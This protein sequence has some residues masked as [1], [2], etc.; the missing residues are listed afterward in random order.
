MT[1]NKKF[2][3]S[4]IFSRDKNKLAYRLLFF[5]IISSTSL[6]VIATAF[7]LYTSF[8]RGKSNVVKSLDV[9]DDSFRQSLENALWEFNFSQVESILTGIQAK[10][11]VSQ[12]ELSAISGHQWKLGEGDVLDDAISKNFE[13]AYTDS[14]GIKNPL[15]TLV[16]GLSLA[17]VWDGIWAQ[18]STLF[19]SNMAKTFLA[20]LVMLFVFQRLV[21]QHLREIAR[22]VSG[23]NWLEAG[24]PLALDRPQ[25]TPDDLSEIVGA[26]NAAQARSLHDHQKLQQLEVSA[27]KSKDYLQNVI[28]TIADGMAVFDRNGQLVLFNNAFKELYH[29]SRNLI[30]HGV[31]YEEFVRKG[32]ELGQYEEIGSD[33]SSWIQSRLAMFQVEEQIY[34]LPLRGDRWLHVKTRKTDAGHVVGLHRDMTESKRLE[35]RIRHM[36]MH[37]SLT[38]LPN[39]TAFDEELRRSRARS[40]RYGHSFALI[41]LDLDNFKAVND[42]YGHQVGDNLLLEIARRLSAAVRQNDFVARLGGDEFAIIAEGNGAANEFEKLLLRLDDHVRK[43]ADITHDPI[44]PRTS[45]GFTTFPEDNEDLDTLRLHADAALYAAK[46]AGRGTWRKY[47]SGLPGGKTES[48]LFEGEVRHGIEHGEFELHYQPIVKLSDL[49]IVGIEALL[50]WRHPERGYQPAGDFIDRLERNPA[51]LDVSEWVIGKACEDAAWLIKDADFR[52]TLWINVAG[53]CFRWRG[54]VDCVANAVSS[55]QLPPDRVILEVTETSFVEAS[56]ANDVINSLRM[57]GND[58]AIDDFGTGFSSLSRLT[59]LRV[60]ILKIDKSFLLSDENAD[61]G[62]AIIEHVVQLC[63]RFDMMSTIEGIETADHLEKA[64]RLGCEW[65]QGFFFARPM[66]LLNLK[67]LLDDHKRSPNSTNPSR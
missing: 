47:R 44:Y 18:L 65:G 8:Q 41:F 17:N 60:G 32:A 2:R 21:T 6:S 53:H 55:Q 34:E 5:I 67:A 66:P 42:T 30:K 22:Y 23:S 20:S 4:S 29:E 51:I 19:M 13:L 40:E 1:T 45:I 35:N 31:N 38:G 58:I 33:L 26:I 50:R 7:Q 14:Q 57:L 63:D 48:L 9:I 37:D 16:V 49:S 25:Q 56:E 52:G 64:R 46:A 59:S 3:P 61:R 24:A 36:A 15:G 12:I 54:F 39:R 11:G 62:D 43:V 10:E 28:E 27:R